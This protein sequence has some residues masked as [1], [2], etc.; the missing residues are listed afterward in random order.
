MD[1]QPTPAA[2][3][4]VRLAIFRQH[5]QLGQLIDELE[6]CANA[7]L[8]ARGEGRA[9]LGKALELLHTHFE[10]HLEY[11]EAQLAKCLPAGAADARGSLLGDHD[12]QRS[13][14]NALVHDR[15]VFSDPCTLAHE[16]LVF[17]HHL[18]KEMADEDSKLRALR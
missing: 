18:R 7:V 8:K 9:A 12:D 15:D 14:M 2:L 11:E 4:D 16:A 6:T 3:D 17:V 1:T 10:R 5:T 13:R